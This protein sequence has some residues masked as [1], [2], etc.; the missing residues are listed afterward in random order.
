V[1]HFV[2]KKLRIKKKSKMPAKM[3]YKKT[4]IATAMPVCVLLCNHATIV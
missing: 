4:G 2:E 1:F 3:Y